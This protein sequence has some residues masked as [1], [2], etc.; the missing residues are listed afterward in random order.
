M[1]D[2][3]PPAHPGLTGGPVYLDYNATHHG[4][5]SDERARHGIADS[6]IRMSIGLEDADD[7]IGDLPQ[8]FNAD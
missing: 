5:A 1:T 4:L 7:L 2:S 3:P 6:M 8:A